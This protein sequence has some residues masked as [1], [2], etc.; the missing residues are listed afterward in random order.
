MSE[1]ELGSKP[2]GSIT[3]EQL[4]ALNEE[5]RTLVRAGVPLERGLLV[6]ARDLRGRLRRIT[7]AL[8][9]RLNRGES[10]VEALEGEKQVLPPLYRAVVEAGAR[11]GQLPVALEGLAQYVRGYSE[12]RSTIGLALWYPLVVLSLAYALFVGM[13]LLVVPRFLEAFR[14]LGLESP[15]PLRWLSLVG[16]TTD[17]WWLAGPIALAVLAIAWVRSG[18]AARF[19]STSWSWLKL[20]PWMKSILANFETANFCELLAL[21]LENQVTYPEALMLSAESTGNPRL[22]QGARVLADAISRG[23][24][25]PAALATVDRKTF[26]P[27]LRWVLATGQQ[28]GSLS[29]GLRNLAGHYRKRGKYLTDKLSVFLPTVITV[30]IGATATLFYALA[31]FI[32]IINL[33]GQLAASE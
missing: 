10:L 26:L 5:I 1:G 31:L 16:Q 32:P 2:P 19:Q 11:S 27:M 33:L 12:A 13:V 21:L 7:S 20:F 28:Q 24:T 8:A 6:A 23:Q 3:I 4:F 17:Y 15:A 9:T 22:V 30:A 14:S 29:G 25:V 18:A